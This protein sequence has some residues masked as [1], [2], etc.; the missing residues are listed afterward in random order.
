[1]QPASNKQ[2]TE[3]AAERPLHGNLPPLGDTVV[4]RGSS[5]AC[6]IMLVVMV[7]LTTIEVVLRQFHISLEMADEIGGYLLAALT[8]MSLS[9]ALAG[10][11]FHKVEFLQNR[12]GLLGKRIMAVVFNLLSLVFAG[13]M[14]W[15]L[16]RLVTRSYNSEVMA[17]TQLATP[18]WIPQS[19]M[20]IGMT[21][22][23]ITLLRE[24]YS[25][26]RPART[27]G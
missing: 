11:S 16:Y 22:L 1:M 9:V 13:F 4:E 8:F 17:S 25:L 26:L 7:V 2:A 10:D 20:L 21:L 14:E 12:L 6:E 27:V 23:I 24:L 3:G 5:L 18:L 19:A 15:Q